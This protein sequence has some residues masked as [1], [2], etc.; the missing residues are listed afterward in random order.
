MWFNPRYGVIGMLSVPYYVL[1]ELLGPLLEGVGYLVVLVSVLLGIAHIKIIILFFIV[2]VIYGVFFSVG[3]VLLEEI[4]FHRYPRPSDLL[5]LMLFAVLENFG[6]RQI[7]VFWRI[8]ALWDYL[9]GVK[10]WGAMQRTG[11]ATGQK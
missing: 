8:K 3:A 1:F 7:T 6:Y 9:R 11:F 10:T 5:K 4:S 2:S